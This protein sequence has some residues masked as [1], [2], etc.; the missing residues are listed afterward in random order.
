ML[1]GGGSAELKPKKSPPSSTAPSGCTTI[2]AIVPRAPPPG[3]KP[4]S[5][6]PL[7]LSRANPLRGTPLKEVKEPP[8]TTLPSVC[9]APVET[10]AG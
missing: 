8:T 2:D 5:S 4:V 3:S 9:S 7:L 10:G 1:T 6:V